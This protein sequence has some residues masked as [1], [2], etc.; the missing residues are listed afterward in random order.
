MRASPLTEKAGGLE[1]KQ[2][3]GEV[4]GALEEEEEEHVTE[5]VSAV[6]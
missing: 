2:N 6:E 5:K 3:R 1:G 4:E